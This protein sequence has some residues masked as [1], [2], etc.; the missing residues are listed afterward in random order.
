[1]GASEFALRWVGRI[2]DGWMAHSVT[3]ARFPRSLDVIRE[4]GFAAGRDLSGFGNMVTAVVN[5]QDDAYA[6][7]VDARRYLDL[8]YGANYRAER[9]HAWGR[10][11]PLPG[12]RRGS[13]GPADRA[14]RGSLSALPPWATRRP[15]FAVRPKTCCRASD[16]SGSARGRRSG[17]RMRL[18]NYLRLSDI[19]LT[20]GTP[21]VNF[22][23][24]I[25]AWMN[26]AMGVGFAFQFPKNRP[27][28]WRCGPHQ[29]RPGSRGRRAW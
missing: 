4:A 2:E 7:T 5:I 20:I 8:Y 28:S 14:A 17:R 19:I 26:R 9:L 1:M 24:R 11:A 23:D 22:S 10:S 12:A 18:Q 27:A 25:V 16:A 21:V 15:S 13:S 6:A 3:P 29:C